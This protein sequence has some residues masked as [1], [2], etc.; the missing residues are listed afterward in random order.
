MRSGELLL[1]RSKATEKNDMF[2]LK[3]LPRGEDPAKRMRYGEDIT[4]TGGEGSVLST[5][6]ISNPGVGGFEASVGL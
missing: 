6:P 2:D 3:I 5:L 4:E 1:G